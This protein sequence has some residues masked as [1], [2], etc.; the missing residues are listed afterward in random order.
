MPE[1]I[2][3]KKGANAT[4]SW[5]SRKLMAL[6]ALFLVLYLVDSDKKQKSSNESF[7]WQSFCWDVISSF[8]FIIFTKKQTQNLIKNYLQLCS[9]NYKIYDKL[10][11]CKYFSR[12]VCFWGNFPFLLT[13]NRKF[14][15]FE[16]NGELSLF[17]ATCGVVGSWDEW[18]WKGKERN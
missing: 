17:C 12:F 13:S 7:I 11:F 10:L 3:L 14:F 8:K 5:C 4:E 1:F 2:I 9:R 16:C 18:G 15:S 6:F